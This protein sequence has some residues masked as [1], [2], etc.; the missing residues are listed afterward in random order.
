M[1][2]AGGAFGAA[3]VGAVG[4]SADKKKARPRMKSRALFAFSRRVLS[5]RG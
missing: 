2:V 1:R 5:R 3:Q 4:R